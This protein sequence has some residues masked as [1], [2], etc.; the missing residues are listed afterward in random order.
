[1]P[2][3]ESN[4]TERVNKALSHMASAMEEANHACEEV[5]QICDK[6]WD[7]CNDARM[8]IYAAIQ[9]MEALPERAEP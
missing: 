4:T 3:T 8:A 5:A 1:M 2:S 9:D 7:I 6:E